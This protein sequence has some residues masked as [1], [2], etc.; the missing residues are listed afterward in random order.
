LIQNDRNRQRRCEEVGKTKL[1]LEES[2]GLAFFSIR[3]FTEKY[4]ILY[5]YVKLFN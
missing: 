3:S 2:K 4:S 1:T 5:I